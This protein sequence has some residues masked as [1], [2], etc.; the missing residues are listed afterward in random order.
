MVVA[1][2]Q[3]LSPLGE[4]IAFPSR[5]TAVAIGR[6][7]TSPPAHGRGLRATATVRPAHAANASAARTKKKKKAHNTWDFNVK[8][9]A[10]SRQLPEKLPA[11]VPGLNNR[12]ITTVHSPLPTD[13]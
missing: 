5:P 1:T 9:L 10:V 3:V 7:R 2:N 13:H 8:P 6:R 11:Q 4:Q 12:Q